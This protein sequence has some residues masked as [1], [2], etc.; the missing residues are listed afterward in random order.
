MALVDIAATS[1]DNILNTEEIQELIKDDL[2]YR[3]KQ[4]LRLKDEVL[5]LEDLGESVTL[6]EFT[7]DDFRIELS[8]YYRGK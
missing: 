2:K 6:N 7:L 8:K 5:D 4:L 1:E 3:D